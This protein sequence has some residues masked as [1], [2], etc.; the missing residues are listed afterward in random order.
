[1]AGIEELVPTCVYCGGAL[2][3]VEQLSDHRVNVRCV[4][5][6]ATSMLELPTPAPDRIEVDDNIEVEPAPEPEPVS[7]EVID[8]SEGFQHHRLSEAIC[9]NLDKGELLCATGAIIIRQD[10]PEQV[11][12]IFKWDESRAGDRPDDQTLQEWIDNLPPEVDS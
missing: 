2:E 8:M 10:F 9:A 5:C 12:W 6:G 11:P 3:L 7:H 1:M 4:E